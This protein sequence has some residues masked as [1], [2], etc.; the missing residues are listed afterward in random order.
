M[1]ICGG[2]NPGGKE[3]SCPRKRVTSLEHKAMHEENFLS[4]WLRE[5]G[6]EKEERTAKV[7]EENV[8]ESGGKRK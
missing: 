2:K 7:G 4:S 1:E 5:D 8:E 6:R 3:E